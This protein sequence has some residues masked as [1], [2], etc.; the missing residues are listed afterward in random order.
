VTGR[1]SSQFGQ[2]RDARTMC[3]VQLGLRLT[4]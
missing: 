2:I 3:E 1:N 4:F